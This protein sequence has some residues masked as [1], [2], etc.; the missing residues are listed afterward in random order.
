ML[1][2]I[3]RLVRKD[4]S[5]PPEVKQE[6]INPESIERVRE[7]DVRG[8]EDPCVSVKVDGEWIECL[9]T[10]QDVL[11]FVQELYKGAGDAS[12]EVPTPDHD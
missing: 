11:E 10:V 12:G 7:A 4:A 9:G 8:I 2:P 3:Q 1:I 5:A 6:A